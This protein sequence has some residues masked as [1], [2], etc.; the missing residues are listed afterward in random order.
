MYVSKETH[1]REGWR[2]GHTCTAKAVFPTPP[3][4]STATRQLSISGKKGK[5]SGA[6]G[7]RGVERETLVTMDEEIGHGKLGGG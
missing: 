2:T 5:I 7:K 4:P 6:L 3:S 1:R